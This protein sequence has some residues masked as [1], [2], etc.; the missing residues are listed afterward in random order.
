MDK[1][2][3]KLE[4][5]YNTGAAS[6]RRPMGEAQATFI[7]TFEGSA[8]DMGRLEVSWRTIQITMYDKIGEHYRSEVAEG[9]PLKDGQ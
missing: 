5:T 2:F 4:K 8:G 6:Q 9:R 7:N 3:F 1:D